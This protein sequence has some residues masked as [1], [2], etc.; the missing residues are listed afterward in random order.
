METFVRLFD[1]LEEVLKKDLQFQD[2]HQQPNENIQFH[3]DRDIHLLT[4]ISESLPKDETERAQSLFQSLQSFAN[5]G[6]WLLRSAQGWTPQAFFFEGTHYPLMN[7]ETRQYFP[8]PDQQPT[9]ILRGYS[10]A[11]FQKLSQLGIDSPKMSMEKDLF[12]FRLSP[13]HHFLLVCTLPEPWRRGHIEEIHK[14]LLRRMA[15]LL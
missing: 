14:I 13:D 5:A 4:S 10:Q 11:L 7:I 1:H 6:V 2:P 9:E 3:V 8:L 12:S 15:E